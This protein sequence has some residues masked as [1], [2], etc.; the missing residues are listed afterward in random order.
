M[1]QWKWKTGKK[2]RIYQCPLKP[3]LNK[4]TMLTYRVF[5]FSAVSYVI[6]CVQSLEKTTKPCLDKHA[7]ITGYPWYEI[8]YY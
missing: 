5:F 2:N 7:K 6:I 1:L 8:H 4:I 3:N